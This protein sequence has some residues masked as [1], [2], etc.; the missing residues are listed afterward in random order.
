MKN[1]AVQRLPK[2]F[3]QPVTDFHHRHQTPFLPVHSL[4]V[5]QR[6]GSPE[7]RLCGPVLVRIYDVL[8]VRLINSLRTMSRAVYEARVCISFLFP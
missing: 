4:A 8:T 2:L 5:Q 3:Q 6:V 7:R 1:A